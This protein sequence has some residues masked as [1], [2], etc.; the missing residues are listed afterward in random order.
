MGPNKRVISGQPSVTRLVP[1]IL[2]GLICLQYQPAQTVVTA[3]YL[4]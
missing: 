2:D 1:T 3:I 4:H